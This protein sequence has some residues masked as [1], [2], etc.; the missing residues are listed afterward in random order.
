MV[1]FLTESLCYDRGAMHIV[2]LDADETP[3]RYWCNKMDLHELSLSLSVLNFFWEKKNNNLYTN[4]TR[5]WSMFENAVES[6]NTAEWEVDFWDG[7]R[8][9]HT[10]RYPPIKAYEKAF[11]VTTDNINR[12]CRL[13]QLMDTLVSMWITFQWLYVRTHLCLTPESR[14]WD[15]K[16]L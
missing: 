5:R 14:P 10:R 8:K 12:I 16:L 13:N 7:Q 4:R 11:G 1:Q 2:A 3:N 6:A 9:K 15:M